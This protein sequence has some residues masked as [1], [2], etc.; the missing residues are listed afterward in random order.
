ME[1]KNSES[2]LSGYKIHYGNHTGYSFANTIDVGNVTFYNL[3]GL[4]TN[5]DSVVAV[6]A[7]D[8]SADGTDDMVEGNESW[9]AIAETPP[10]P[11][12]NLAAVVGNNNQVNLNWDALAILQTFLRTRFSETG[13]WLRLLLVFQ[14]I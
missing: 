10:E 3:S 2:D 7:Y 4:V 5:I 11:I 13:V 14:R 6:T 9:Y 1:R 8:N 12:S